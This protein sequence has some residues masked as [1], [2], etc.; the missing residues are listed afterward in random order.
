[1]LAAAK[2]AVKKNDLL[3]QNKKKTTTYLKIKKREKIEK[4]G[5]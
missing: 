4:K 1:M 3:Q 2:L 5:L